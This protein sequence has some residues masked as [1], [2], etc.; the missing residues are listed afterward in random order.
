MCD[1]LYGDGKAGQRIAD[2]LAT[3]PVSIEKKL[4]FA[5]LDSLTL[6]KAAGNK[7]SNKTVRMRVHYDRHLKE[8]E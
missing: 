6:S 7:F 5:D 4:A 3:I 8:A 2:L 1:K